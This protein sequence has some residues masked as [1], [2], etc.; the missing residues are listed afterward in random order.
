MRLKKSHWD[1]EF[2]LGGDAMRLKRGHWDS[3]CC[4]GGDAINRVCTT[5]WIADLYKY[6][7]KNAQI[8]ARNRVADKSGRTKYRNEVSK[9]GLG[10]EQHVPS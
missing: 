2:C 7:E 1:S 10:G 8:K 9:F 3:D 5:I 6:N 4:L